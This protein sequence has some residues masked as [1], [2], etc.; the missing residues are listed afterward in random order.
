MIELTD[1][2]AVVRYNIRWVHD[3][4]LR[5]ILSPSNNQIECVTV[6]MCRLLNSLV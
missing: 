2:E 1:N 6:T 3:T 4:T 5:L